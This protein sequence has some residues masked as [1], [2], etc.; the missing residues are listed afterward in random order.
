MKSWEIAFTGTWPSAAVLAIGAVGLALCFVFY[1]SKRA[2]VRP[3]VFKALNI[4]RAFGIIVVTLLLLKPVIRYTRTEKEERTVAVLL[5][6]SE[7][8]SIRDAAEG[9]S[10]LDAGLHLLR[11][12]PHRLLHE[13]GKTHH[14]RFF[15]FG[16]LASESDPHHVLRADQRATAIGDALED[17]VSRVGESSLSGVVLLSDGVNTAG[18]DPLKVA[19]FL[20][21]PVYGIV[22]GGKVAERG[23]FVD[24]GIASAP[25]NL[26]FIVDNK[27]TVTV[28]VSNYG[29]AGF[30]D[31]ER[32]LTLTLSAGETALASKDI[33]FPREDGAREVQIEYTPKEVGIHKLTLSLPVLPGEVIE[34]NNTR[35]FTVRVTDPKIRTLLVEGVPRAE[36]RFL[37]RVLES[38]P[39]IELTSVVKLRRDRFYLQGVDRGVDLSRGL[40]SRKEEYEK[41]DVVILGDIAREEFTDGQIERLKDFVSEGG[42]LLTMGGY[43]AYG[44]GGWAE[45]ALAEALPVRM[46]GPA[47][48][49]VEETFC[50][51]LT[52]AGRSHPVF[53]GCAELFEE[54]SE[55]ALLDG[56]NRVVGAKPGATV[57][58][59]HPRESAGAEPMPIVV[60]QR[61]GAGFVLALTADTT[62][63]WKFQVEGR[64][65][66]SP[67]YRFWRQSVRWLAGRK[68]E[69]PK[70]DELLSAWPSKIEYKADE[71]VL[72]QAQVTGRDKEPHDNATVLAELHYPAPVQRQNPR[73]E[74]YSED[75]VS[76]P[77]QRI[78]LSLGQYQGL[79]RPPVS[80]I[81]R[82]K[83][84]ASDDQGLLG[85]A[86]FEFVVGEAT[87]EFDRVDVDEL[88]LRAIS[89]ETGGEFHTLATASRIPAELEKRR[90]SR[91][92][93]EELNP[94]KA[95]GAFFLLFL[96]CV[97]FEWI[98]RK[99]S[100]LS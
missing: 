97:A 76:L 6:V 4:L 58:A 78:P 35:S 5:D 75:G 77:L 63:K 92:Y 79:F 28:R 70:G 18:K 69:A 19:R 37:R 17:A 16:A 2:N 47:D 53:E 81:Y 61:F 64:G 50:A 80:G 60:V 73:G 54:G 95:P 8:M 24:V 67:Y 96:T 100:A 99:R 68:K 98:L 10:R 87:T 30:A 21:V 88:T 22:L 84:S 29:L 36:Y 26:E 32:L 94:W 27:A 49:H 66:D 56:A 12:P 40:P 62:W 43:N 46:G 34:E 93:P 59:V 71:A 57:L 33:R 1:R 55:R 11:E 90:R 72:L 15:A 48:G 20:G 65:L 9:R 85:Q 14:V 3:G 23:R 74:T 51:R 39:N 52:P 91:S 31:Q 38:D 13:M 41:F 25:H 42:G 7:S 83:V 44:A 45:S 89:G 82:A 86:E